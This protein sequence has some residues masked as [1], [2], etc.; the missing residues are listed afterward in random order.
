MERIENQLGDE[1][2][3]KQVLSWI[4][5]EKRLLTTIELQRAIAVGPNQSEL[6]NENLSGIE[7]MVSVYA[8]LITIDNDPT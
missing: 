5:C 6:D 3:A 2:L 4:I 7:Y 8:G 1:E